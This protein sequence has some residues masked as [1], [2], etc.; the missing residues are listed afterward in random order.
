MGFG[1]AIYLSLG[2]QLSPKVDLFIFQPAIGN[3]D[4][5]MQLGR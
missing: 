1:L 3:S 4:Y 5:F 2:D